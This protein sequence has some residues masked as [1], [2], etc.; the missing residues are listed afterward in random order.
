VKILFL[1]NKSRSF[2]TEQMK[3]TNPLVSS[4]KWVGM[5]KVIIPSCLFIISCLLVYT[6]RETLSAIVSFILCYLVS[7]TFVCW[8]FMK[9]SQEFPICLFPGSQPFKSLRLQLKPTLFSF[10]SIEI[11]NPSKL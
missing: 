5:D 4:H 7:K 1:N 6:L 2:H 11:C 10:S 3:P 9:Q 8:Y